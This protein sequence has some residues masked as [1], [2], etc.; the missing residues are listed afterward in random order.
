LYEPERIELT[1]NTEGE[2]FL[3]TSEASYPGWEAT[4]NGRSQPILT[5][6]GAF[7]G[8]ELPAG[9]NQVVMTYRPVNLTL[10]IGLTLLGL[11][12]TAVIV[13]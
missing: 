1:V 9:K 8:L 5:T 10:A 11:L 2:A 3:A 6:N 13:L 4:V 7:R 12:A